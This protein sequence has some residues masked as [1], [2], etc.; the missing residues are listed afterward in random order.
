MNQLKEA[1]VNAPVINVPNLKYPFHVVTDASDYGIGGCLYQV[2]KDEIKYIGF[3]AR[4]LT[5]TERRYGSTRR[6]LLAVLYSFTKWRKWLYGK[7]FHLFVDNKALLEINKKEAKRANRIIES[8][9]E[10]IFE[11]D[12]DVTYC[13]GMRNILADRLSSV[14]YKVIKDNKYIRIRNNM[15]EQ[16]IKI[17]YK[18]YIMIDIHYIIRFKLLEV[19]HR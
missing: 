9:Y 8:Y 10:T 13:A 3:V 19:T 16:T 5:P 7:H 2:I 6:E 11:M 12:F 18:Y 1:L 15:M 4:T 14:V 17:T